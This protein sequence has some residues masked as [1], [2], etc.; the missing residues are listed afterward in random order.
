MNLIAG[1]DEVGRGPLAGPVVAAAVILNPDYEI[2]GLADS[3]LLTSKR[4]DVLCEAIKNSCIAW[5]VG[6][7]SVSEIDQL[8]ILQASLL[9][10]SRAIAALQVQPDHIQV[11][12]NFLPLD[13]TCSAEAIIET[14]ELSHACDWRC[15]MLM[16]DVSLP[17]TMGGS[18]SGRCPIC[19]ICKM[20]ES[21]RIR[22]E[23]QNDCLDITLP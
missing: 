11:D 23:Y 22:Y 20:D 21:T 16:D 6:S 3:K 15:N 2:E 1:V 17:Q 10:M 4:R 7:A 14:S 5:A 13:I 9:A 8:N 19:C 12:G 18:R